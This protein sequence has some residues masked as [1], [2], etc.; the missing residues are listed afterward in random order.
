MNKRPY[1]L[2]KD[3]PGGAVPYGM[4]PVG[5]YGTMKKKLTVAEQIASLKRH[6]VAFEKYSEDKA[7]A[8]LESNTYFFK[9]K[10]FENNF[11]KTGD[12]YNDLDFAYLAD[13]P[14]IDC[15]L[16]ELLRTICL[17][18]EHALKIRFNDLLM[19][20]PNEDG[21]EVVRAFDTDGRYVFNGDYKSSSIYHYSPYTDGM[22]QKYC[23]DPAIW[24]LWEVVSFNDLCK[25]YSFYLKR[26]NLKDNVTH[27][28]KSVRLLRNAAAHNN[29]LLIGISEKINLTE[30]LQNCLKNL[31]GLLG[32]SDMEL[33]SVYS[34]A[35]KY[36]LVH[37]YACTLMAFLILVDSTGIRNSVGE[38][39]KTF[40]GR[41]ERY[42]RYSEMSACPIL[43]ETMQSIELVSNLTVEYI[44]LH[45]DDFMKNKILHTRPQ[46]IKTKNPMQQMFES[47]K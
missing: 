22:I 27:F 17:N 33:R 34:A 32:R 28:N 24:N 37:D 18:I 13:L 39:I 38:K 47:K 7:A 3:T 45:K 20:D 35:R 40:V 30:Y 15:R 25:L 43:T 36:P 46:P 41:M 12:R 10:A 23:S 11:T 14:T 5:Y 44:E 9:L 4:R 26:S 16:R 6:G 2:S 1:S 21:Y 29:C 31:F 8:F 19:Q 42:H